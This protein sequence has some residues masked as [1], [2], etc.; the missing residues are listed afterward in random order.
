MTNILN[1]FSSYIFYKT[2]QHM[3]LSLYSLF[4]SIL[5]AVP[6]GIILA[7]SKHPK[8]AA[9]IL[10]ISSVLQTIPSLALI[11]LIVAILVLLRKI[12][13]LPATGFLPAIIV[14][15]LYAL[16]PILANTYYGIKEVNPTMIDIAKGMGMTSKQILFSIELPLALTVIITGI[17]ISLVWTIGMATLTSLVGSG[18]LGDLIMQGLRSMQIELILAGTLPAA[19][20]AIFFDWLFALAGKWLTYQPK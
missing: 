19:I 11:A 2:F 20:L 3:Q 6:L 4:L 16:L 1:F 13:F 8:I 17:R 14:L 18:G 10:K 7:K 12:V 9:F 5:I 15:S